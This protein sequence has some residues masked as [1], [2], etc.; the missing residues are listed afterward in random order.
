MPDLAHASA[1]D[2]RQAHSLPA[3]QLRELQEQCATLC[4]ALCRYV[5]Q[6]TGVSARFALD[7]LIFTTY[8]EYLDDLPEMPIIA[9]CQFVPHTSPVLWQLD[10]YPVYAYLDAMLGGDGGGWSGP[11]RELTLLERALVGQMVDEFVVTWKDVWPALDAAGA[12]VIEVRQ[13]KG[14]FGAASLQEAMVAALITFQIAD[15]KGLM[16]IA[17]PSVALK[18]LIKQATVGT[19]VSGA[20]DPARFAALQ[21]LA[22]CSLPI[23]ARLGRSTMTLREFRTLE[24]GDVIPVDR[25]PRDLLE[26]LL[27]GQVKFRGISGLTNGHVGIRIT[28]RAE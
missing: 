1:Y 22:G 6:S 5:P 10:P 23:A 14:R 11:E 15:A 12:G 20:P 28:E 19:V 16:R 7:S 2:F 4:R 8:D 18:T 27:A 13:S 3:D 21:R 24:V 9:V 17:L 25:G 26:L